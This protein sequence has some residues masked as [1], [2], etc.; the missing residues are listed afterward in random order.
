MATNVSFTDESNISEESFQEMCKEV[1]DEWVLHFRAGID[2]I[3]QEELDDTKTNI[4]NNNLWLKGAS[5]KDEEMSHIN[6]IR[7]F[8]EYEK[9]IKFFKD[10]LDHITI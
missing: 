2:K 10:M 6:N 8:E 1:I 7:M 3:I 4:T 9:R 5:N